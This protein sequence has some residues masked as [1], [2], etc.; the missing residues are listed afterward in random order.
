MCLFNLSLGHAQHSCRAFFVG[1]E[2]SHGKK[3]GNAS[4]LIDCDAASRVSH[5]SKVG[6]LTSML[7]TE[8]N[9]ANVARLSKSFLSKS[10]T[11]YNARMPLHRVLIHPSTSTTGSS[12]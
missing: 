12:M 5:A 4:F 6:L 8:L 2:S 3:N 9:Y 11:S 7:C 1:G 10:A